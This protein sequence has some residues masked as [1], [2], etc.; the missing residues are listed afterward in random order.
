[1]RTCPR[2]LPPSPR[3][4]GQRLRLRPSVTSAGVNWGQTMSS[5]HPVAQRRW[6]RIG[7]PLL[8]LGGPLLE[9][10]RGSRLRR[11]RLGSEPRQWRHCG[12][13]AS[14]RLGPATKALACVAPGVVR[15]GHCSDIRLGCHGDESSRRIEGKEY[16]LAYGF[17]NSIGV[18]FIALLV[19]S[20]TVL[21]G[22]AV[23]STRGELGWP[24]ALRRG[25]GLLAF[26]MVLVSYHGRYAKGSNSGPVLVTVAGALVFA[27]GSMRRFF[28]TPSMT[29]TRL[30][31]F[32]A[33]VERVVGRPVGQ[34]DSE[35]CFYVAAEG[36][37]GHQDLAVLRYALCETFEPEQFGE[38][39]L[40]RGAI[41]HHRRIRPAAEFRDRLVV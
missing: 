7:S 34:V 20:V 29:P 13:G 2:L 4:K 28:R 8:L 21:F 1:M 14:E 18:S 22:R 40:P 3:Q 17:E 9:R 23:L 35:Y 6:Q 32:S 26:L 39:E 10:P 36:A 15:V 37:L 25:V 16:W 27:F 38:R 12:F 41:S 30:A 19:A 33:N 31:A 5:A 24:L 11:H